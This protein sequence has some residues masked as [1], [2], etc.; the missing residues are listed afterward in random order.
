[1]TEAANGG[2]ERSLNFIEQIV[3]EEHE[4]GVELGFRFPPEPNGYLHIG[5]AKAICVNFMLAE[6]YHGT[7]NL[8]FDDTNPLKE[9]THFAE[10][11]ERDIRWLGFEWARLCHASDYFSQLCEWAEQL[12]NQGDAYVC[13]L[14]GEEIRE[15]RGT[16]TSPGKES[17]CR[18]RSKEE[19]LDLF[20]RMRAGEFDEGSKTLR[21]RIDMASP[22]LNLRDPVMYRILKANHHRVGTEW[23]IY[24]TYD[25]THGQSDA[26][27]GIT[28]S[29]C[30]LEFENHRPLYEWYLEKIG[31]EKRPR[32]IEFARLRLESTLMSKRKLRRLV[33]EEFVNGWDDPRMPTLSGLRRRGF[34][35]ESI[36]DFCDRIGVAR[37]VSTIDYVVLE[38]SLRED[39]NPRAQRFMGVLK[40]LKVVITNYPEGESEELEAVG[41][42][43]DESAGT[44]QVP[45]SRTIYIERDDFLED[46]PKKYFR[47]A[48]GK[49]VRLRYAYYIT[50]QEVIKDAS[51]EIS[52]VHCSYDPESRGGSTPDGR[53]VK[54][55]IHW[56]SAD[57]G[58]PATVNLYDR[59]FSKAD[60]EE[61]EEGG[62][63]TDN[64]NPNSLEVVEAVVEPNVKALDL[65]ESFQFERLGYFCLDLDSNPDALVIN[66]AVTLKDSW[67]KM[68]K[69]K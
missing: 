5:H 34:T 37:F 50:C 10:A 4:R 63:F 68:Q 46:P 25:W 16:L 18:N 41:N 39:L 65:G 30:S 9:E 47:L 21:A 52:E 15:Y 13:D 1:M 45:F 54:G 53:K 48:P 38:N 28:H 20:R 24:P 2:E 42:P 7:C 31:I 14:N 64:L 60:P 61:I 22:N 40:P 29:L 62:D 56:V 26:I 57:H 51:G 33:E 17:P 49:E 66:R 35:P 12:I 36:R 3:R 8:R 19:N 59:L 67:A 27:E 69:K 58:V 11:I 23:C 6:R 55:T 44:R 32:Q 43:E